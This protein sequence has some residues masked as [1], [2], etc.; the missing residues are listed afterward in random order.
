METERERGGSPRQ[1]VNVGGGHQ[2]VLHFGS[3]SGSNQDTAHRRTEEDDDACG[4]CGFW[5]RRAVQCMSEVKHD[6]VA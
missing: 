5:P 2:I 1:Y 3:S 4:L 6:N